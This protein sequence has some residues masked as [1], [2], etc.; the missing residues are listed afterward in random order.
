MDPKAIGDSD[1]SNVNATLLGYISDIDWSKVYISD[2]D[3]SNVTTE[4]LGYISDSDRSNVTSDQH[5]LAIS[6]TVINPMSHQF[7]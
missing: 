1:Q 6:V 5:F 2:S 7:Y 3:H 4:L